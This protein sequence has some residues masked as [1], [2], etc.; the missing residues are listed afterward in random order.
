MDILKKK[1]FWLSFILLLLVSLFAKWLSGFPGLSL[2]GHL[3]IALIIGMVLQASGQLKGIAKGGSGFISNKFL[4]LGIILMGFRLN[5][6]VL[7][8]HGVKTITL[9]IVVIAFT[10]G[11]IYSLAKAAGIERKL[12]LLSASGCGICGAAA[13][14]GLSPIIETDEDDEVISVA[15]VAILGTIFTLIM[16]LLR[17]V[18]GLTDV[19]FGVLAG[20]S[21]HEIAH[22]VAAGAAGGAAS[23]NIAVIVKLSRVLMLAP[24]SLIFSYIAS[25][26]SDGNSHAKIQWPWFMLGFII[27][28][29]IGTY[30]GLSDAIVGHL[31]DLAYILLGMAMAALG[32]NVN[33]KV[34]FEKGQKVFAVCFAG[35][36]ALFALVFVAAKMFF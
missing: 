18:M 29:A 8:Q 11:L 19:Q 27:S 31:V 14:L 6:E 17:P 12:S 16:V 2:I 23:E 25:R 4:R 30:A 5:L 34:V 10:I 13:V 28:S 9:A 3:V 24:V 1:S 21:L 22:A 20:G 32:V 7:A 35:S 33:F 26:R 15:V 36:V